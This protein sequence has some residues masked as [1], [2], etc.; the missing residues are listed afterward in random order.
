MSEGANERVVAP[1]AV[2]KIESGK[3]SQ[4]SLL[5]F[6]LLFIVFFFS[7]KIKIVCDLALF[8]GKNLNIV[9]KV[10]YTLFSRSLF[11]FKFGIS[12]NVV[13]SGLQ[14]IYII[15]NPVFLLTIILNNQHFT[16]HS[17]TQIT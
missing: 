3:F 9:C 16:K 2:K 12:L 13:I 6:I 17:Q 11:D 8:F 15:L 1:V 10:C 4:L 14:A 7:L 5:S